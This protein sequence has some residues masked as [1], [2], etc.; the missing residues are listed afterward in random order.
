MLLFFLMENWG[1]ED[2]PSQLN[3]KFFF[4]WNRP[5]ELLPNYTDFRDIGKNQT[6]SCVSNSR[7]W[8]FTDRQTNIGRHRAKPRHNSKWSCMVLYST[9]WSG[10]VW[11]GP[12]GFLRVPYRPVWSHMV[13]YGPLWSLTVPY[14]PVRFGMVPYG[15]LWS[16]IW[17]QMIPHGPVYSCI[18]PF[19]TTYGT[20]WS[21]WF[22]IVRYGPI[23][24]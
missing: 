3:G 8:K 22:C 2:P 6:F 1:I 24:T 20:V 23:W 14:G 18:V 9:V 7:N 16:H 13:L 21:I 15:L 5:L 12:L 19:G 17:S 4:V 10:M 11:Y